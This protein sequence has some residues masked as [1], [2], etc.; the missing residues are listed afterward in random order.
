MSDVL[1]IEKTEFYVNGQLIS[2]DYYTPY[3]CNTWH[4]MVF[5]KKCTITVTAYD[6]AGNSGSDAVIIWKIF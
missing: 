6:V 2:T 3:V 4:D 1:D 5:L